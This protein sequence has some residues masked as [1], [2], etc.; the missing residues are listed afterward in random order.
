MSNV[1]MT[2]GEVAAEIGRGIKI[3]QVRRLFER[4]ILPPAERIGQARVIRREDLPI[5]ETALTQA[6]YLREVETNA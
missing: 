2:L 3:W 4:S 1:F 5:V 6:G